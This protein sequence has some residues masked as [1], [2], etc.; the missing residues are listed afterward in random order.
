MTDSLNPLLKDTDYNMQL[1][2]LFLTET[3]THAEEYINLKTIVEGTGIKYS[4]LNNKLEKLQALEFVYVAQKGKEKIV[5]LTDAG[6]NALEDW[7]T[8]NIGQRMLPDLQKKLDKKKD[9]IK[10]K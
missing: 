9:S 3:D 10:K 6:K 4:T 2:L 5:F 1:V 7:K 8:S